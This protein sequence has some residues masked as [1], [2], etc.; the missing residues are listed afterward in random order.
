MP[1]ETLL[2][3]RRGRGAGPLV[4]HV[5]RA[6]GTRVALVLPADH[7]HQAA[8]AGA[9]VAEWERALSR[10][11]PDSDVSRVNREREGRVGP[12]T[13]RA[14]EAALVAAW[15]TGGLY[16]PG[17][18][19]QVAGAGYDR[20]F[21]ELPSEVPDDGVRAAPGGAWRDVRLTGDRLRLPPGLDLD[22]GGIAKGLVVDAVAGMLRAERVP[23]GLVSAGGDLAVWGRPPDGRCWPVVLEEVPARPVLPLRRG[24]LATSSVTRR[25]WR[26]GGEER[27][28]VIDPRTGASA[29]TDLRAVSVAADRCG[30]AEA[31]AT[32]AL[33]LGAAE[34]SAWLA[35]HGLHGVLVTAGG[36][37]RTV[38]DWP[39][40]AGEA[41]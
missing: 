27:H 8:R 17:L 25:R 41:A 33:V 36:G 15:W 1:P 31:A 30:D 34:G 10:F 2:A 26:G 23:A 40:R 12:L 32:A 6:M 18:G 39:L 24:A 4:R 22:L 14:V 3:P 11:R 38:G 19:A 29:R 21:S 16:D 28:H 37:V 35:G 9:V 13:A 20:P 5:L 7:A